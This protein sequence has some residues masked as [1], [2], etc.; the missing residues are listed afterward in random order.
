MTDNSVYTVTPPN[1]YLNENGPSV[2]FLG[3]ND[4][5]RVNQLSKIFS[6][7]YADSAITFYYNPGPLDDESMAWNRMIIGTVDY[8]VVSVDNAS[9]EEVFLGVFEAVTS[10]NTTIWLKESE[11]P[12]L[13]SRVIN[14]YG[15]L[16]LSNPDDIEMVIG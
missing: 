7:K 8:V 6:R 4:L 16:M 12:S 11:A 13:L 14:S 9:I 2:L 1:C 3:I 5:A 15:M 10:K